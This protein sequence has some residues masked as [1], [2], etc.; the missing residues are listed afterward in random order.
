MCNPGLMHGSLE[1]KSNSW[2]GWTVLP[3]RL[4]WGQKS[5]GGWSRIQILYLSVATSNLCVPSSKIYSLFVFGFE[6][7][8][9]SSHS[10]GVKHSMGLSLAA[11]APLCASAGSFIWK[12]SGLLSPVSF[13]LIPIGSCLWEGRVRRQVIRRPGVGSGG[14]AQTPHLWAPNVPSSTAGTCCWCRLVLPASAIVCSEAESLPWASE[15]ETATL[16]HVPSSTW[17]LL[18]VKQPRKPPPVISK[19]VAL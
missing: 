10:R 6:A 12:W 3:I 17:E 5:W 14:S 19:C 9:V 18:A 16:C 15:G 4:W 7:A 13:C 2:W 1:R 8:L 11:G